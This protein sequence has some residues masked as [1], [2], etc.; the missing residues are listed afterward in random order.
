MIEIIQCVFFFIF[1]IFYWDNIVALQ[2]CVSFY[3]TTLWISHLHIRITPPSKAS[4]PPSHSTPLGHHRTHNELPCTCSFTSVCSWISRMF[5]RPLHFLA[6]S[7]CNLFM[8]DTTN[9]IAMNSL[10]CVPWAHRV[11]SSRQRHHNFPLNYCKFF[12]FPCLAVPYYLQGS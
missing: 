12:F 7:N 8:L 6:A 11:C 1:I 5:L 2:C 9:N 4:L 10:V 3:C